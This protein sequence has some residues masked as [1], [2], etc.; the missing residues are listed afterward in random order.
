[1]IAPARLAAWRTVRL[2]H[3]GRADLA[4]A[5]PAARTALT[6]AR[7]RAL[8]TEIV[9]GVLRWRAQ[10]DF[11]IERAARRPIATLDHDVLDICRI[12]AFQLLHLA[13]V[14]SS[15]IVSDAVE[16]TRYAR[17]RSATGFVNAVLRRVGQAGTSALPRR[18]EGGPDEKSD[19]EAWRNAALDYLSITLSH[20]RWLVN[21]WLLRFGLAHAE[22]WARFNNS[23]APLTLCVNAVRLS[24]DALA[25]QLA[26]NG[27]VARATAYSPTG[28]IATSGR[29]LQTRLARE[30]TFIVQDEAS[31]VVGLVA[32]AGAK[33]P[34]LDACAAPGG[35]TL[36]LAAAMRE[37][38]LLV[39]ADRRPRRM[40]LL[41]DT[42]SRLGLTR[43]PL[44]QLDLA[45]GL[46]FRESFATVL[47]DAP[48]SG[49]GTLRRDPDIRWRR[50]ETDL[51]ALADRQR[52]MLREAA[53]GIVA[54]GRLVYA[55]CS[56]EPEENEQVV[57]SFLDAHTNF[58]R[59]PVDSLPLPSSVRPLVD[60]EGYLRTVPYRDDLEAFFAAALGRRA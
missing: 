27:V 9:T 16:L 42:L 43:V 59:I 5:L 19:D 11:L 21:R 10:L 58:E 45:L 35:K 3:R 17:K 57:Q 49:L 26:A 48:C 20:P 24:R 44:V 7:D 36:A 34:A 39:A 2:V 32:A 60:A 46:P 40:A 52:Q 25:A 31:Q 4:G 13:R 8:V 23:P 55:T 28:L 51:L 47:V 50:E 30:G 54:G 56:S 18:P 41:R 22:T 1:M 6:D 38:S 15:A 37:P 12:A 53:R 29:P 33:P 14:P